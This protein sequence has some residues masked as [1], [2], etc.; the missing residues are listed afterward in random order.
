[1][2]KLYIFFI[3]ALLLLTAIKEAP[4]SEK[5]V[6]FN[7]TLAGQWY[8]ADADTLKK[9][10]A[11]LFQKSDVKPADNIIA[12]ILPHAG[13]QYSGRTAAMGIQT[14]ARQYKRIIV[15]G[16]S[17]YMPMK[18]TLSVPQESIYQSP[19]GKVALDVEFINYL[20]EYPQFQSIEQANLPEHSTQIQVPL[21]QYAQKDFKLVPIVA[22]QCSPQTISKVASILKSMIDKDTLIIASS[23]FTH[24]GPNY[25]YIPFKDNIP[26]QLKDLDMGAFKYIEKLDAAGFLEYRTKTGATICG[27]IPISILLS[28]SAFSETSPSGGLDKSSQ[29][30]LINYATSGQ[31]TGDFTNSVSYL[32]VAFSGKWSNA[33]PVKQDSNSPA[34]TDEDKKQLLAFARKSIVY[35]LD[36]N[37]MLNVSE[38]NLS[39][40][41]K[42]PRAAFVTLNISLKSAITGPRKN[43]ML[44][45]C[46][47]D[48]FP[49][50]PLYESVISNAVNAAVNDPRFNSVS[51]DELKDI[52]IEIS[53][54][55]PPKPIDSYKDIRIGIDGVVLK[56]DDYQAV[57]LPQVAP[58]QNWSLDEMLQNLSLKAGLPTDAYKSGTSFLTFQAEVFGEAEK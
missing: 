17:H 27:Y 58:E 21:L 22:G 33:S 24:Y 51:K 30:Q 6:I 19:L 23:D 45:G 42:T 48:I 4:A 55:T 14:L 5:Q 50:Q 31:L 2:K 7:S 34:L 56:K 26:Q 28:M 8:P 32:S 11:K 44:R 9:D 57:F 13:Y 3:A 40:R 49:R 10:I 41:L 1:M 16:P 36:K 47:G 54:L 43:T 29:P 18:D 20:L 15:I 39:E 52:I 53:A 12:L 35:Y 25:D 37:Q 38:A 46:I